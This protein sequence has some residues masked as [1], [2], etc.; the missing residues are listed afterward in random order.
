MENDRKFVVIKIPDNTVDIYFESKEA[1]KAIKSF[2]GSYIID[3]H[4]LNIIDG[5]PKFIIYKSDIIPNSPTKVILIYYRSDKDI[6]KEEIEEL[7]KLL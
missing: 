5:K 6:S 7:K 3:E 1:H 2:L 4:N